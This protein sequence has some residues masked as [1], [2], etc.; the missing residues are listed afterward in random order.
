MTKTKN[1]LNEHSF[2]LT[3]DFEIVDIMAPDNKDKLLFGIVIESMTTTDET[4]ENIKTMLQLTVNATR[5]I[6]DK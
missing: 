2:I 1:S 4:A 5:R 3:Y 6:G